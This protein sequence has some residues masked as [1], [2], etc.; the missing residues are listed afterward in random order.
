MWVVP[1]HLLPIIH[2][3]KATRRVSVVSYSLYIHLIDKV[4][5]SQGEIEKLLKAQFCVN[6]SSIFLDMRFSFVPHS[7]RNFIFSVVSMT[8]VC[9][10]VV[11]PPKPSRPPPPRPAPSKMPPGN[12][13]SVCMSVTSS[14]TSTP[15]LPS[16]SVEY[17]VHETAPESLLY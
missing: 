6:A 12:V 16:P 1:A 2:Q 17:K 13:Y 11:L 5:K 4:R 14:R 8:F 10:G 7:T 3:R 9:T 15:E